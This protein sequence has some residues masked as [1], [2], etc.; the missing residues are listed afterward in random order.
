MGRHH[1]K[2]DGGRLGRFDPELEW[3][4]RRRSREI[5]WTVATR[6][7]S[8]RSSRGCGADAAGEAFNLGSDSREPNRKRMM[9]S[10]IKGMMP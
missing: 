6:S 5:S 4:C 7:D 1:A 3:K 8:Y 10:A 2:A 9:L